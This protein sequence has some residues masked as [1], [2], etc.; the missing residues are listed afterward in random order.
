M[1]Q[2]DCVASSLNNEMHLLAPSR[3]KLKTLNQ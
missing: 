1:R 2:T 3:L